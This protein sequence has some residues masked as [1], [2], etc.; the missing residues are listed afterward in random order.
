M[1]F[2][3]Y[4]YLDD[5]RH[6]DTSNLVDDCHARI[7]PDSLQGSGAEGHLETVDRSHGPPDG[8]AVICRSDVTHE[9][10]HRF[11]IVVPHN[12]LFGNGA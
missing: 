5:L 12:V 9:G 4:I 10:P 1:I 6:V 3:E 2:D 8:H 7:V 11:G